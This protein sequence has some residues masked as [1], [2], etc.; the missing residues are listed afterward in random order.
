MKPENF[1]M[2]LDKKDENVYLIDFG[3]SQ[4][5]LDQKNNHIPYQEKVGMVGT[6]RYAS[7]NAH[8]GNE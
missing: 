3:L 5:Y 1:L 4:R 8:L 2:G 7:L 6:P